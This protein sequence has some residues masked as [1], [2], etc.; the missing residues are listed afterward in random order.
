MRAMSSVGASLVRASLVGA[1]LLA[2][3]I[4]VGA[5][6]LAIP[7]AIPPTANAALRTTAERTGYLRTGRYAE[8]GELCSA[9]ARSW[10]KQ[11]RCFSMG[12]T[13]EGRPMWVLAASA[14]GTLTAADNSAKARP[15]VLLQG[16]IHAGEIDGKDAGFAA[17]HTLL[18]EAAGGQ[19][20]ARLRRT[21]V[22]FV[23]VFNVDGHERFGAWNRPNQR[24]PEE[25]GWRTTAQNLNLNR[26]YL[27]ADAPEMQ[28]ML[29]LLRDWNPV[30]YADLHVT[31]GA[32]FRHDISVQVEPAL[33]NE[34]GLR[35]AGLQLRGAVLDDLKR[36]G[37]LP[38]PYYPS[39]VAD[40]DPAS[41]FAVDVAPP[42]FSHGYW[43]LHGRFGVLVETHSWKDYPTR[44]RATFHTILS[45]VSHAATEGSDWLEAFRAAER[46]DA[47][48]AGQPVVLA[49]RNGAHTTPVDFLGYAYTRTP[50]AI[51]GGLVT[52]YD[53]TQPEVWRVPLRDTVE[54]ALSVN[55]PQG[56]YLV[57]AAWAGV[58]RP[59]LDLHGI[60]YRTITHA[61]AS[62]AGAQ[63]KAASVKSAATSFE[64]RVRQDLPGEWAPTTVAAQVGD[65]FV[66]IA[67]A[68][69]RVAMALLEPQAPDSLAAWGAF[70]T[71]FERKEYME[72]YVAEQVSTELL[73]KDPALAAEFAAKLAADS[74]FAASPE[75]RLDFFYWRH[76][77][78]DRRYRVYPV[79][80]LDTA[81]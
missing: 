71:A 26:D 62:L 68:R 60:T 59:R 55:A 36:A 9:Y 5:S 77:S 30:I 78:A 14:D 73:A 41:G 48:I 28:A 25:M 21:T 12:T 43:G 80:R 32:D 56:G 54:P 13:P 75:A 8:V 7:A 20:N 81:P 52:H 57:P 29:A 24:G 37:S 66:P 64:G 46:R 22:L 51:S 50:S 15:V 67:Q 53:P 44:V 19:R 18:E 63:F 33:G 40:D 17:L 31:D 11:V 23:P 74:A 39:L 4:T 65:L 47:A 38:L 35:T 3:P 2:T 72:A 79:A 16:G 42:R 27:K 45:L 34:P 58:V 76:P 49:W 70:A 1:C 10:P 6:L 61:A 69:S